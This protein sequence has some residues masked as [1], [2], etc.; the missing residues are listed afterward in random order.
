MS[1]GRLRQSDADAILPVSI[2]TALWLLAL[3]GL[4]IAKPALDDADAT[5]WIG[6]AAVGLLSGIGG[7]VFL[8]WRKRRG[9]ARPA[10]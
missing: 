2:G 3:V 6:V 8:R 4:I 9:R 7:I 5:W 10:G 1:E